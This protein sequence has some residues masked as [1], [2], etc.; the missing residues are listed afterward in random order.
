MYVVF[1]YSVVDSSD[2]R[3]TGNLPSVSQ[4]DVVSILRWCLF[5]PV[6]I[7]YDQGVSDILDRIVG[8][9]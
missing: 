5:L 1:A 3:Y 9:I 4:T 6:P 8:S 2:R 7:T